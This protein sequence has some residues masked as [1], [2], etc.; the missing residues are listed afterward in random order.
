MTMKLIIFWNILITII[1]VFT[2]YVNFIKKI[3]NV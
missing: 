2:S 3:E 1:V